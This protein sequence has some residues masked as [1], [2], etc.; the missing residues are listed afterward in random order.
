PRPEVGY[1]LNTGE[2]Q[3][4]AVF[5]GA[6][7]ELVAL[8]AVRCIIIFD[9]YI[10]RSAWQGISLKYYFV[11]PRVGTYPNGAI[12]VFQDGVNNAII[13][14]KT[15]IDIA[16]TA[17]LAVVEAKSSAAGTYP[18]PLFGILVKGKDGIAADVVDHFGA[19]VKPCKSL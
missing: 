16:K 15:R 13:Q 14:A 7:S 2:I 17:A 19:R 11:Q 8:Q 18:Q 10:G 9:A 4:L 3:H 6:R 5:E 1:A 12:I